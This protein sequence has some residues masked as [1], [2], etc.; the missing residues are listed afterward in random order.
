MA[1]MDGMEE[2]T[3]AKRKEEAEMIEQFG[4]ECRTCRQRIPMSF[5]RRGEWRHLFGTGHSSAGEALP[6]ATEDCARAS[7][8]IPHTRAVLERE[9]T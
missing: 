5:P 8:P 3:P 6:T 2:M 1:H 9:L 7:F 4:D